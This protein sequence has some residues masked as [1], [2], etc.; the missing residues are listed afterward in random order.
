MEGNGPRKGEA[1]WVNG[2]GRWDRTEGTVVRV[3]WVLG[4]EET[5]PASGKPMKTNRIPKSDHD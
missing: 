3:G 5:R 2:A 1:F 4:R